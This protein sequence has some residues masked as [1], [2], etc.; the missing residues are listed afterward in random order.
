[1]GIQTVR[2]TAHLQVKS[3]LNYDQFLVHLQALRKPHSV[4]AADHVIRQ[5]FALATGDRTVNM[6]SLSYRTYFGM[7]VSLPIQDDQMPA[8]IRDHQAS[9]VALLIGNRQP[10]AQS[11]QII[12]NVS[13][14]SKRLNEKSGFE[15]LL[16]NRGGIVYLVPKRGYPSPHPERF[17]RSVD[18]SE[19]ALYASAFL[20][21]S[22][23]ERRTHENLVDFL[24]AKV[25]PWISSPQVIFSSSMTNELQWK[26]LSDALSLVPSLDL[27]RKTNGISAEK[28]ELKRDL[29]RHVP[30]D[31][32]LTPELPHFLNNLGL[33]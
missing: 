3:P 32:W 27:W 16:A 25:D 23:S 19:L 5:A 22:T 1:M 8:F 29:F 24:R 14:A 12:S 17:R 15:Y 10:R 28:E 20:E 30:R 31:W 11:S 21:Y 4:R 26:V 6:S 9:I 13:D 7:Q 33:R 18:I 2:I